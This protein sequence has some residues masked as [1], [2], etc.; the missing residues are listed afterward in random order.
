MNL[1]NKSPTRF[2][3]Q[4]TVVTIAM[5]GV[6]GHIR[7]FEDVVMETYLKRPTRANLRV[8]NILGVPHSVETQREL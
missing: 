8:G 1:P 7:P 2:Y 3:S 4:S 5:L 6:S